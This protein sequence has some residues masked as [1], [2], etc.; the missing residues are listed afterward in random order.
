ML[1]KTTHLDESLLR[2][3]RLHRYRSMVARGLERMGNKRA[4][5]C[6]LARDL[7][8]VLPATIE[9]IEKLG[10][11]FAD[12]RVVVYENDSKDATLSLLHRWAMVNHRVNVLSELR[13][14]PV[15]L[16]I[17]C[18][19]RARR[20][21]YYRNQCRQFTLDRFSDYDYMIVVDMDI[22]GGWLIDGVANTFGHDD[23]DF[24]GSNGILQKFK[25]FYRLTRQYDAW[26]YRHLGSYDAIEPRTVNRMHWQ[27]GESMHPVYSCFGGLG[28]Y[29]MEAIASCEYGG[30]D[31]EHVC[32]HRSMR[33]NGF[34]R[35]YLNPSQIVDY[36]VRLPR[37]L[38][39]LT[40][41]RRSGNAELLPYTLLAHQYV[42]RAKK[43]A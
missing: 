31:C 20:M 6:G 11:R 25:L 10:D 39:L 22:K 37:V 19:Q 43:S 15:N 38:R 16:P 21:A 17:R 4:V 2:G 14:D 28:V 3:E 36:G 30:A 27:Q 23:W 8:H 33:E 41:L 1:N 29:R 9:R 7:A 13:H 26:A 40:N 18:L 12:Y 24:V 35:L 32:L 34:D 42:Y 5:I